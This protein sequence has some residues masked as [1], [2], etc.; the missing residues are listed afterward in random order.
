MNQ[1]PDIRR[2]AVRTPVETRYTLTGRR[3]P[4]RPA[5]RPET[6]PAAADAPPL[7]FVQARTRAV[8]EATEQGHCLGPWTGGT[9]YPAGEKDWW[10]KCQRC[11]YLAWVVSR[12]DG[13]AMVQHVP[14]R[15]RPEG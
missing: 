1:P 8:R 7:V 3:S 11:A 10:A 14:G 2:V 12:R 6:T 4:L 9:T 15:C 5:P 13:M